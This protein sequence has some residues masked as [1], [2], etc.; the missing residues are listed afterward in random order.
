A[1]PRVSGATE[2]VKPSAATSRT[3]RT[4]GRTRSTHSTQAGPSRSAVRR[5]SRNAKPCSTSASAE[6]RASSTRL[7]S[8]AGAQ[9]IQLSIVDKNSVM[10]RLLAT[11]SAKNA[12]GAAGASDF[13]AEMM[14]DRL[15]ILVAAARQA[16]H[17]SLVLAHGGRQLHH[18]CQPMRAF[19]RRDD[20]FE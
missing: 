7:I 15:D 3:S 14:A 2:L 12:G 13:H 19:E 6:N 8:Q 10:R 5:S 11:Q 18:L 17:D 16:Q 4:S 1:S 9:P 20:A